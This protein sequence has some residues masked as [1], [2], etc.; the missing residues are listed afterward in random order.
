MS[1]I[2]QTAMELQDACNPIAVANTL[3]KVA[4]ALRDKGF[5]TDAIRKDPAFVL[6]VDKLADMTGRPEASAYME[7]YNKCEELAKEEKDAA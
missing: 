7:V 4:Q 6:I 3:F 5:G 2:Y 1:N